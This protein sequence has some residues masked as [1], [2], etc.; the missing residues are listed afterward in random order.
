MIYT[1]TLNPALDYFMRYD[2]V[3][4]GGV[5][6]TSNTLVSAGGKGILESR[7][8]T[9]L[10]V[11]NIALGFIG[12]FSGQAIIDDLTQDGVVSE[13]TPIHG[14]TRINVKVKK[15][16]E[17]TSYDALGPDITEEEIQHF[18]VKFG[19]LKPSDSIVFAGNIP[20][21]LGED[22]YATLIQKVKAAGAEFAIDVDGQKLLKTLAD[23]PLVIKPN[24]AELAEIF[25]ENFESY[26]EIIP[27]GEKL[28]VMGAQNVIVS[29][30]AEGALLFTKQGNYYAP[31]VKGTLKNSIGAG[32]STV[33]GFIAEYSQSQDPVKAFKQGVACGTAKAFS[34]D[35]PTREFVNEIFNKIEIK[36]I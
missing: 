12:G 34:S 2:Q 18:L 27:Y 8:L 7:M 20:Q 26:E 10:G 30:G 24:K 33:A 17:E 19:R 1:V 36:E 32:D 29:M 22:F 4:I 9:L 25:A 3:E 15:Q 23:R 21:V 11:P 35:M 13:F 14:Q 28:L 5:N 6:R 16:D 31:V